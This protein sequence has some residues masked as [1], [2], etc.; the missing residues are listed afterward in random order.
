VKSSGVA[1]LALVVGATLYRSCTW[2]TGTPRGKVRTASR[3]DA[4]FTL[5]GKLQ[6]DRPAKPQLVARAGFLQPQESS[7]Q[8]ASAP[9]ALSWVNVG[10]P[11]ATEKLDT[12]TRRATVDSSDVLP[13]IPMTAIAWPGDTFQFSVSDPG[14]IKMYS[15]LL[16]AGKRRFLLPFT[17]S[18]PGGDVDYAEMAAEDRCFHSI[19]GIVHLDELREVSEETNGAVKYEARHTVVGL[20]RVKQL[21]N[22]EA[23]YMRDENGRVVEY[24][25]A[26]V[27]V[28]EGDGKCAAS[29]SVNQDTLDNLAEL[30][31]DHRSLAERLEEP[32]LPSDEWIENL[33]SYA[34]IWQIADSWRQVTRHVHIGR[35]RAS[36]YEQINEFVF[37]AQK[38]GLLPEHLEQPVD[39]GSLGIPIPDDIIQ[40]LISLQDTEKVTLGPEFWDPLL[41]IIAA[42]DAQSRA[43]LLTEQAR[44]EIRIARARI[45]LK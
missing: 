11:D 12:Q 22:P 29:D 30:W 38:E 7:L 43:D 40:D 17:K 37:S 14:Y 16:L 34:S 13:I 15:D 25:R 35:A 23:V 28:L 42:G 26:E 2:T 8:V 24:M 36:V 31:Q 1:I 45:A 27:E 32:R 41:Q 6:P 4:A 18:G 44:E 33:F 3:G 5:C 21:L 10:S 20:A 19:G 39:I 9:V